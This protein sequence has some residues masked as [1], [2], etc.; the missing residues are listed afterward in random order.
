MKDVQQDLIRFRD[1][2][3]W[4]PHHTPQNLAMALSVEAA[5]LLELFQWGATPPTNRV[6]EEVADVMIYALNLANV[7]GFDA[8]DAIRDKMASNAEKYPA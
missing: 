5:E 6:R 4:Q 8:L 7:Y 1:A 3:G 2:R